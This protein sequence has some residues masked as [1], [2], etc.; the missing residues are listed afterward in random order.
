M[1]RQPLLIYKTKNGNPV[2]PARHFTSTDK[3][4]KWLRQEGCKFSNKDLDKMG[5]NDTV[6]LVTEEHEYEIEVD[7]EPERRRKSSGEVKD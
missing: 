1:K 4:K 2:P 5:P 3:A 6:E 7:I